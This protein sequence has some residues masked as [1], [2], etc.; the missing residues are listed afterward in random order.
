MFLSIITPTYNRAY[1]LRQ[2]YESLLAQT[3]MDF[4]WIVVDDGST[5]N[6]QE[7]LSEFINEAK[8]NIRTCKQENGGKHRAHNTAV[9]VA[10]GELCVCLDSDDAF[11][12]D[13]VSAAKEIWEKQKHNR[14]I[15]GILAKRG[16]FKSE[17]ELCTSWPQELMSSTMTDLQNKHNFSG[18]TALYFRTDL[19]QE[20]LFR[21]FEN[22]KFLPEDALYAELDECGEMYLLNKVVYLCE[23]RPDGLTAHYRKLLLENSNGTAYSYYRKMLVSRDGSAKLKNAIISCAFLGIKRDKEPFAINKGKAV[24]LF[25]KP[26]GYIYRRIKLGVK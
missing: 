16:D 21:E 14:D 13:A 22:E 5:D 15:I 17:K 26:L 12:P 6:T 9:K 1:I 25:A 24:M 20:H 19:L 3:D 11:T 18:D 23:Y 10:C 7:L 8:I 2:C 4:E